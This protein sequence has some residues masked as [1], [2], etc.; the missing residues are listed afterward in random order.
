MALD[1]DAAS[2][3]VGPRQAGKSTL[4]WQTISNQ[5]APVLYCNC[6]EPSIR[7]LCRSPAVFAQQIDQLAPQAQGFFFDEIQHL[8]DAGLFLKGLVDLKV[9]MYI[10]VT[11]SSSYHLRSKTRESLAGRAHRHQLLPF[12]LYEVQPSHESPLVQRVETEKVL[13]QCLL[14]GG[15]PEVF[16]SREKENLLGRLVEAFVLRDASDLYAIKNPQAFRRLLSLTASQIG[17][18]V[19]LS[20]WSEILGVSVNTVSQYLS[21][22]EESH[23]IRLIRPYVGG[24]RA[25]IT[26][27]P[28]IYFIDNGLRNFLFGGFAPL[29]T[30]PDKGKLVENYVFSEL[31]K[32]TNPLL[33]SIY[34]WRSTSQA[35]VDFV[36]LRGSVMTAV[37]VKSTALTKP[38]LTRSLQSFIEAYSPP[39]VIVINTSLQEEISFKNSHVIF[40]LIQDIVPLLE[41]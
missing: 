6:E 9:K 22:L 30:R 12:S 5:P 1:K 11:G 25:E 33:D 24:K 18:L 23:I 39:K 21:L 37:E 4:I 13:Q 35:E 26:S 28:K 41:Q 36:L 20:N 17:D 16:L 32:Y 34:Y 8:I 40:A 10:V 2:L 27:R 14:W 19:N 31:C 38:Q 7:E 3:V 29:E 15:Y